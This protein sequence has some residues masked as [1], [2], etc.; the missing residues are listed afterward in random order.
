MS[1]QLSNVSKFYDLQKAV[2]NISLEVSQPGI[3]GFLGPNG[4]GKSTTMKMITG[5][6][7]YNTGSIKV[8]GSEVAK[9][10]A[11]LRSQI[12]YLSE[13]NPLYLDMFVKEYLLLVANIYKLKNAKDKVARVIEATGLTSHAS[14]KIGQ[15][16]KGYRQRVG[17]AQAIIHQPKIL[18][19]DEPTSG[20]DP[21]QL[22]EIRQLIKTLGEECIL[23]FSSHIM[24]EAETL[25]DRIIIINKGKIVADE[26]KDKMLQRMNNQY[27]ILTSFDQKVDFTLLQK[28]FSGIQIQQ[29]DDKTFTF[30]VENSLE[31]RKNIFSWSVQNN[32]TLV[33]LQENL[34]PL[35]DTFQWITQNSESHVANS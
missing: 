28:G 27:E 25:C 31:T 6:L 2:D 10:S 32:A 8:C 17:I 24:K 20:L 19:L 7:P 35:E 4:A 5:Y 22:V 34:K 18:I 9:S 1:I 12:G 29:I 16:S 13:N 33:Q 23:L 14:K 30:L 26:N 15:L 21:N 11:Q 3:I